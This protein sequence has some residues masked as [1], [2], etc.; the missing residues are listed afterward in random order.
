MKNTKTQNYLE[1]TPFS[2]IPKWIIPLVNANEYFIYGVLQGYGGNPD[3]ETWLTM[4]PSIETLAEDTGYS[5]RTVIRT[6]KSL[7]KKHLISKS[8]SK[9]FSSKYLHNVYR[10]TYYVTDFINLSGY[11]P[12]K[13]RNHMTPVSH[14]IDNEE[15]LKLHTM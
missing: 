4:F 13:H 7:E 11:Q 2:M 10:L 8:K 3:Q 6:L 9:N 15:N 5:T 1:V 14:S 12:K